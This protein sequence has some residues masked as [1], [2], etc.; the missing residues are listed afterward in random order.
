VVLITEFMADNEKTLHD[1]DGD[2]SDWIE[3]YNKSP[4]TVS[5]DGWYLTDAAANLKKW[6]LPAVS[7]PTNS[8]LIV[9]AS[10]K[11][12]TNATARLHT[13]FQ[14]NNSGEYLGLI[15][16]DGTNVASDFAPTYPNP[17]RTD[18]SYGRDPLQTDLT[19]Y[20][21]TPTPGARNIPG[22]AGVASDIVFSRESGTFVDPFLLTLTPEIPTSNVVIRY[23]VFSNATGLNATNVPGT[24]SPIY[25][26]PIPITTTM[27][28]RARAFQ[29]GSL[30]GRP[31]SHSYIALNTNSLN[32]TSDLPIVILHNVGGGTVPSSSD[33]F[34]MMQE[35]DP[36]NGVSSITNAPDLTARGI[37]HLRGSSTLGYPKG[38]F[39]FEAEDEFGD[40]RAIPFGGMPAESDWALYAPNN[41]EPVLIH[42]PT[43]YELSRQVGRYA[44][45]TRLVLVLLNTTGGAINLPATISGGNYNGIYVLTEKIKIDGDRVDI[46]RLQ[47]EDNTPPAV[48][49]GYLLSIDRIPA[50]EVQL[51][52][53]G[54][55][56]NHINPNYA[57]M[58]LPQRLPQRLYISNYFAQFGAAVASANYTN[59]S[60]GYAPFVDAGS[61]ID[62]SILNV[63]T[64]NVDALRLSGYFHKPRNGGITMGPVWDF[65]R[66]QNS[67]DGRDANP[68][69]F[70]STA[71]D[72]GTDFFNPQSNGV[73]WWGRMFTDPNFFQLWV[74]RYQN[75]RASQLANT[76][77][78]AI[79]D[80][81]AGIV[82]QEQPREQSRWGITPRY[83]GY[84]GEVAQMKIWY[85]NRLDFID[86]NFL[87]RPRMNTNGGMIEAGFQ[88][89]LTPPAEAGS[90]MYYTL[91]GTDPRAVHGGIGANAQLYT[92]P[93]T[94]TNNTRVTTRS[95]NVN[96]RNLTGPNNPPISVPWSG[97][98]AETFVVR[99][100][101]LIVT[102]LMYHPAPPASSTDTNDAD[103]FEYIEL[104]NVGT[105]T[106]N[107]VGFKF[108][109]GIDFTFTTNSV[110][111]SLLPGDYVLV[112][113]N[114]GSFVARYGANSH[115][116]GEYAGNFDNAGERVTLVGPA[117]EPVIDFVYQDS[118]YGFSDGLGFSLVA[119]NDSAPSDLST[120][121]SW[122]LSSV[123]GGSPG[124]ANPAA[125]VVT[126][127]VIVNEALT[128]TDP[129]PPYDTIELQNVGTNDANISG[130]WL[131][132][133]FNTPKKFQIPD[134][135]I[136]PAG[137]FVTF[138]EPQ[139]NP[140]GNGFALGSDGDEIWLFSG[141]NGFITGYAQGHEF[142][143]AQN[144]RSFGRY[145]N[146]QD[147]VHFVAQATNTLGGLNSLPFVGPVVIS[148]I[149]YHP[150]ETG[151][152]LNLVDNSLDEF[153]E[154]Y[155]I[156]ETN[157]PL[158]HLSFPANTWRLTSAVEFSFPT[159]VSIPP[160]NY[161]LVV[162]F[163]PATNGA[164]F[165]AKYGVPANI[166]LYGPYIGKLDNSTESVRLRRPDSPNGPDVPYILVDQVDYGDVAPWPFQ[167]DGLG[168][169]LHRVVLPGYGNDVTNWV[170]ARAT[171]GS[172]IEGGD[173][174]LIVQQ[175]MNV[176]L[177]EGRTTNISVVV[178][179]ATAVNYQW[180]QNSN[181]IPGA[182][183]AT[184]VFTNIQLSQAGIYRVGV[185]NG[186]GSVFSTSVVVSVVAL[187][188]ITQQPINQ[189]VLPGTNVTMAVTAV[190]T[191]TLRYQWQF[192]ESNITNATNAI[193]SFT[194]ATWPAQHGNYRVLVTDDVGT[195]VS[196]NVFLYILL[197]PAFVLNP[198]PVTVLAG[199]N[200]RF[201]A[202]ATGAPPIYYRWLRGGAPISI[203]TSGVLV[204]S[205]VQLP[206]GSIRVFATNVA[207][208]TTGVAMTPSTGVQLTV[209]PDADRDGISDLWETAFF[210]NVNTTNNV[211]NSLEDPDSDGMINRDEYVAGTNP[212]NAASYLKIERPLV[213]GGA[214]AV[215][216]FEAVSNRSYT[217]DYR[218][219]LESGTW[220]NLFAVPSATNNR[221]I[222]L[223]NSVTAPTRLYRVTIPAA[224]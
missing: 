112:V 23:L 55:G 25:T 140:G 193:Y 155:N 152:I 42:N 79:I 142:G 51:N 87:A 154:L 38:S 144:G 74:D 121:T 64:F 75:L 148:E 11:N 159:N 18:I 10:G 147:E 26:N 165:R 132:D 32:F 125:I 172:A 39:F 17:Q 104:R 202:Y 204:I 114:S 21:S 88:L 86:T 56:M 117:L 59:I 213:I 83:G 176:T 82:R 85:S 194:N 95:Y 110:V 24:N 211:N 220:T 49:G 205:N 67:T 160:S 65:D 9:Y 102:E 188:R 77:I 58:V 22:G 69:T 221:T 143:A 34:V 35:F 96:H 216:Q 105:N 68:R 47:A 54:Q 16:P 163:D 199:G 179:S 80:K 63:V 222:R 184:L 44:T 94:L 31:Q 135:T 118:W 214:E 141:T 122:R 90:S 43:A 45:R 72:L 215:L 108:T 162:N 166:P 61:W 195:V 190:G 219:V 157:V 127:I 208:G 175:P 181:T 217:L 223:T 138:D 145:T 4:F 78:A 119:L 70:R 134:G 6:R 186:G 97:P 84:T 206:S 15:F 203:E 116:A 27:H 210:G 106:L 98:K 50:G 164:N 197:K 14:L 1:E 113:K 212:T 207:S 182:T 33:Q 92:G 3:L 66:T 150:P 109:N 177:V 29:T 123:D 169:S 73:N 131:T 12:R 187:P 174:P 130:W 57:T 156:T 183:A 30:P 46:D 60:T 7:M 153:I 171:P 158:Y 209:L 139:F 189:N 40:D 146:S 89:V 185:F 107:L 2:S 124:A 28:V 161:V 53:G 133:D 128:H 137:G 93:I 41:F 149:M 218:N 170:A 126:D 19:G 173:A 81:F 136:V 71:G 37:F 20:F 36:K 196:T 103:N 180:Q 200:A 115:V 99:T 52:A 129:A 151:S 198:V 120:N 201:T 191:G 8:Y 100:P 48:T 178:S 167:A 168:A 224:E 111:T 13:N 76:N 192:E 91:D 62:H 5:L 101:E